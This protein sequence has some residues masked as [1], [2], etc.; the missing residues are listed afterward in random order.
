MQAERRIGWL[1]WVLLLACAV[2]LAPLLPVVVLAIWSADIARPLHGRLSRALGGRVRLAAAI[3]VAAMLIVVVPFV[4]VV[5]S[6]ALDA[7]Q[8]IVQ[9]AQSPEAKQM[10]ERLVARDGAGDGTSG[11][12]DIWQLVLSQQERAWP[13]LQQLAGTAARAAIGVFVLITGAYAMLVSGAEGYRWLEQHGPIAPGPLGRLRDA[14]LESGR[15]LF[16]GIGGAGLAQAIIATIVYLVLR[17]P[18]ALE[19]G[20]LTFA[21]SIIPAIGTAIVWAPIAIG[22]ALV[23]RT[24]AAIILGVCGVAL[25]GSVD[26]VVKPIL[27]RRGN[28]QLPTFVVLVA[29]LAGVRVMGAW[30]LLMAPLAVRLARA[31]FEE[32]SAVVIEP[33]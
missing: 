2:L 7:Y 13:V 25:I 27:T 22:L 19:L 23:D 20:V 5:V 18:H 1:A 28:L 9:L 14:F 32:R 12:T 29:M 11:D 4:L 21:F 3:T 10:L 33:A 6:L 17:V 24:G 26:N 30:G 15:G 31:A 8:L 16:I